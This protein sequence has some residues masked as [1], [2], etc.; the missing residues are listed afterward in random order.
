MIQ[1]EQVAGFTLEIMAYIG[2]EWVAVFIGIRSL[3]NQA[4]W[5]EEFLLSNLRMHIARLFHSFLNDFLSGI[6]VI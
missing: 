4:V 6:A 2:L 5:T 1:A 3:L